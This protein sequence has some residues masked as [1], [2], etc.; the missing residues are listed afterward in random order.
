MA[1]RRG[2]FIVVAGPDGSGKTT[3]TD[4]IAAHA[5]AKGV[6]VY[7]AHH[8]PG[9]IAGRRADAGPVTDP[10]AKPPRRFP[11]AAAKLLLVLADYLLG[12]A[13][14]W[15]RHRREGLLLLERGWL[16]MAVD[17][18]RY[19]LPERLASGVVAL[20]RVLPRP[21]A[22]LLLTGDPEL[23]H[24]RKPEIGVAEVSRQISSW[25]SVLTA[26]SRRVVEVDTVCTEPQAALD[27]LTHALRIPGPW[28][29]VPGTPRRVDLRATGRARPGLGI[30]QPQS[31]RARSASLAWRAA[32]VP[33]L[34]VDE[35]VAG[36]A[37]LWALIGVVPTG[38]AS[39]RSSTPGRL[40]LAACR[41]RRMEYVVK[42][43]VAD[44]VALRHEARMLAAPLHPDLAIGRPELTWSGSWHDRFVVVTRAAQRCSATPWTVDE[45]IPLA[46]ALAQA[47]VDG[48]PLTHGDLTPWNLVRTPDGPVLLDWEFARWAD[49]P[50]HDLAHFVVQGGALLRQYAPSRAV[51]MLCDEGSPGVRL[52]QERGLDTDLA[53]PM[54]GEYLRQARPTE[55]RAVQFYTEMR[56]LVST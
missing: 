15:R 5:Q 46:N 10:H 16:D 21:D 44:D 32:R 35:P 40:V 54:L 41:D 12:W 48:L 30:Y 56:Q 22:V 3:I 18:R 49:E 47:G 33:G 9:L 29:Q 34:P 19:R 31:L 45:V 38:V 6:S 37:E 20:A 7:R 14:L 39:M 51:S 52:L 4:A 25:R 24:A 26:V 55:P 1:E 2:R 28:R 42:I 8:R 17:P 50:L 23:L 27:A 36:L 43:G 13:V 11:L 53:R